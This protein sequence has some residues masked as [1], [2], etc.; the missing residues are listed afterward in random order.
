MFEIQNDYLIIA[1]KLDI[2]R[3]LFFKDGFLDKTK[4]DKL[5]RSKIIDIKQY[6]LVDLVTKDFDKNGFSNKNSDN[7]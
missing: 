3:D 2:L 6:N 5:K 1:P 7:Q 4:F